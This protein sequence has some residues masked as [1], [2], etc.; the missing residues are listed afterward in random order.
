MRAARA[1]TSPVLLGASEARRN[2]PARAFAASV[3]VFETNTT[4]PCRDAPQ[5]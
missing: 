2:L 5:P 4:S 1:A 3:A